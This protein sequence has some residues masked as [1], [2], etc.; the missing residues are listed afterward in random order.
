MSKER[1]TVRKAMEILRLHHD[2]GLSNREI[3]RVLNISKTTVKNLLG[4]FEIGR[5]HV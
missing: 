2:S 3:A 1:L 4:R 5:A